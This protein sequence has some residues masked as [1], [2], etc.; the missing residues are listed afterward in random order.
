MVR[1]Y[2]KPIATIHQSGPPVSGPGGEKFA[3]WTFISIEILP[4]FLA[5]ELSQSR[6]QLRFLEMKVFP[7]LPEIGTSYRLDTD[8]IGRTLNPRFG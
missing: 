1:A 8:T 3:P 5:T 4:K 6:Y 2:L 7:M